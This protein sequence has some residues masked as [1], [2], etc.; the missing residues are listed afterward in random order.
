M[1]RGSFL[2]IANA[3]LVDPNLGPA[4]V[5]RRA[6]TVFDY[7]LLLLRLRHEAGGENARLEVS[8]TD[9]AATLGLSGGAPAGAINRCLHQLAEVYG[10]ARY[11]PAPGRTPVVELLDPQDRGHLYRTPEADYL[12][13]PLQYWEG[14]W[15]RLLSLK[16]RFFL[17]VSIHEHGRNAPKREAGGE[18]RYWFRSVEDLAAR[19]HV[20]MRTVTAALKELWKGGILGI[21][22]GSYT[23]RRANRYYYRDIAFTPSYQLEENLK[24]AKRD[25]QESVWCTYKNVFLLDEKNALRKVDLGLV[26]SS[27]ADSL[28]GLV[29]G[30]LQQE[31]LVV[32]GVSPN[33]L[34]RNWPPALPEWSTKAVRDAFFASPKFPRLLNPDTVKQTICRGVEAGMIAYASK[35]PEGAYDPF[36][37]QATLKEGDLEVTDDVFVIRKEDA[38]AYIEAKRTGLP[39]VPS[40]GTGSTGTPT[41]P[42]G[43]GSGGRPPVGT[44]A[45]TPAGGGTSTIS[46]PPPT[47]D[48]VPGFRWTGEITP[49]K[50]M[51]FYTKVL[52]RFAAARGLKLT[53]TVDVN[54][55]E[56]VSKAKIE[57]MRVALR[58][59]GMSEDVDLSGS[60]EA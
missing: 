28:V 35:T 51:N 49:Q 59:L 13:L 27:A 20:A 34:V 54:P 17:L 40:T 46:P 18:P 44:G 55:E 39:T 29:L 38:E 43:T 9:A 16:A 1:A 31:D 45:G 41:P 47:P 5:R 25:L 4:M 23:A 60:P 19:Y 10:L 8:S 36:V 26:H 14:G 15:D 52:A 3:F 2:P 6:A 57:E 58:E 30:R 50:W 42:M 53:L 24:R 7:Y 22:R 21:E 56:G 11:A 37:F 33:F 12:P 32:D 48:V